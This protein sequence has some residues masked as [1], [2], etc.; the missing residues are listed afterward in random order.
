MSPK[1]SP[2]K[3]RSATLRPNGSQQK[4]KSGSRVS[5]PSSETSKPS[6]E[7]LKPSHPFGRAVQKPRA[8][9][10]V[11]LRVGLGL[12]PLILRDQIWV[13]ILKGRYP[14]SD[15]QISKPSHRPPKGPNPLVHKRAR[16]VFGALTLSAEGAIG[17]DFKART[18]A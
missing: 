6:S 17:N 11:L 8:P 10:G 18:K 3:R 4:P 1:S 9:C 14:V 15:F 12:L 16:R 2:N 7:S 13:R 5:N